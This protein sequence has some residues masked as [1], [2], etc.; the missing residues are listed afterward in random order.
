M[1]RVLVF[2]LFM[3]A[4]GGAG[5]GGSGARGGTGGGGGSGPDPN[6]AR[7]AGNWIIVGSAA[8]IFFDFSS[9]AT[10]VRG[11][12]QA[13]GATSANVEIE[14]GDFSADAAN[15]YMSPRQWSCA[16]PDPPYYLSYSVTASALTFPDPTGAVVLVRNTAPATSGVVLTYGCFDDQG[17]F[18]PM[19]LV[20][21]GN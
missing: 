13:T 10:Y 2:C 9:D 5:P 3:I 1:T 18:A 14:N 16:P 4:C 6:V 20:P 15:M 17:V 7:L 19:S 21:T 8:A 11:I 12:I